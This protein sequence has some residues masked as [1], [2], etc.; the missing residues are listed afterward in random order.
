MTFWQAL[1][2]WRN[3][4]RHA[5]RRK[6]WSDWS[7]EFIDP[8]TS[9]RHEGKVQSVDPEAYETVLRVFEFPD[10]PDKMVK[11]W[12]VYPD[13]RAWRV[14]PVAPPPSVVRAPVW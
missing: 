7:V 1:F 2:V 8:R 4:M 10:G 3:E 12:H 9:V 5:S 6:R 13:R 11:E 14:R